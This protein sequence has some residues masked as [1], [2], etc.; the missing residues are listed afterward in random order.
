[1]KPPGST[2]VSELYAILNAR[3]GRMVIVMIPSRGNYELIDFVDEKMVLKDKN[4]KKVSED[5]F[6]AGLMRRAR[7]FLLSE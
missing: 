2:E 7:Y 6:G 3:M 5:Q 4:G 1:M